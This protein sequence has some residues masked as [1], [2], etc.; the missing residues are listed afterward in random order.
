MR[1]LDWVWESSEFILGSEELI[2]L[3]LDFLMLKLF[4]LVLA[5]SYAHLSDFS[6]FAWSISFSLLSF[7]SLSSAISLLEAI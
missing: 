1:S 4:Y 2:Y 5:L 3:V 7:L 6:L